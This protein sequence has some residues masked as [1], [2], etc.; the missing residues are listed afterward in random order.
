MVKYS[1]VEPKFLNHQVELRR[2]NSVK[3]L[4]V[5]STCDIPL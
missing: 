4:K 5:D 3:K 1:T 2:D